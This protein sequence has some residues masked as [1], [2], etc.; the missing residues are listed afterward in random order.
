MT[1]YVD[2]T[3]PISAGMQV[4]PGDPEVAFAPA[5]TLSE[6]GVSVVA[7]HLGSHS[8]THIDAPSHSVDG[9]RTVSDISV[10]EL[11]GEAV[12]LHLTGAAPGEEITF[13]RIADQIPDAVPP[14]VVL[15]TGWDRMIG[16]DAYLVH[17]YLA[18]DAAAELLQRG[19]RVLGADTLSPDPTLQADS[20]R[21]PVHDIVLGG[22][23]LIVENLRG[24]SK[25]PARCWI[26]IFPLPL[27]DLDGAPVRAV[28]RTDGSLQEN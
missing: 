17:P 25:L 11:S 27:L 26:G 2:L 4:F 28:A 1:R 18:P 21:L 12:I 23:G 20:F 10:D 19:M 7:L 14:I 24:V 16:S 15:A 8:G 3:H 5:L 13:S 22:D 9:G 6:D